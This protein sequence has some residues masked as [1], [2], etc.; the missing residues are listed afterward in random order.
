MLDIFS[1]DPDIPD[2]RN[3]NFAA[4]SM[5]HCTTLSHYNYKFLIEISNFDKLRDVIIVLYCIVSSV[6]SLVGSCC[7]G[8]GKCVRWRKPIKVNFSNVIL[9]CRGQIEFV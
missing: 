5:L 7:G 2:G 1:A 4:F 8:P 3:I 9:Y 6:C